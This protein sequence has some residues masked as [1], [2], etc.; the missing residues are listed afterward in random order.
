MV[1]HDTLDLST[2]PGLADFV[3]RLHYSLALSEFGRY[4]MG[5]VALMF[6]VTL[7][8]GFAIH[9]PRLTR[10]LF[11]LRPG[12][13][14]KLF[15]Q[16]THNAVGVLALPFHAAIALTGSVLCLGL[17]AMMLFNTIA[18]DGRLVHEITAMR[19]AV[20]SGPVVAVPGAPLPV[21][22]LVA[23]ARAEVPGFAPRWIA[24]TRYGADDGS[25]EVWGESERALGSL[26]S[27]RLRL[28]DGVLLARQTAAARD[29]NH[30]VSSAIYGLHFG[31]YGGLA[32]RWIYFV[33][34]VAG[35]TLT[36]T[37]NLLWI[38][39]RRR[40]ASAEQSMSTRN[41][42]RAT[43][44][45]CIGTCMGI[46]AA[47]DAALLFPS[48]EASTVYGLALVIA[49]LW[50]FARAPIVAARDLLLTTSLCCIG[51]P[52]LNALL[53]QDNLVHS[54]M[55]GDWSLAGIDLGGLAFGTVFM[56]AAVLTHRR[57]YGG[58]PFSVW[59]MQR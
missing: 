59:A 18:F 45:I 35:A 5:V 2:A 9:L 27:V 20:P 23:R 28:N 47:F 31:S 56:A 48:A 13:N 16:D 50:S 43:V 25:A 14:L 6:G 33:L 52:L 29:T 8:S 32:V 17:V 1:D 7:V 12:S 34:G 46:A 15:W 39:A 41:V 37:G 40:R 10:D 57:G 42:S 36:F 53:T 55:N 58:E 30:A 54:M 44:A 4:V 38:E 49:V 11:A 24:Y 26:G 22:Q 19:T 21:D 3:N 51:I